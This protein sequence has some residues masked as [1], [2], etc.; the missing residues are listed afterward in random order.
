MG[1]RSMASTRRLAA[2]L[3][4]DVAGYSRLMGADEEGTLGR[5]KAYRRELIDPK[6]ARASRAASSR[7]PATACWSSLP[8]SVDAV[9][10]AVEVQRGMIERNA[11]YRRR[12]AHRL[13]RRHQSRRR[14]RR[15]RRHLRRRRQRRRAPRSACR[16]RRY[17]HFADGARPDPRQAALPV[18]RWGEQS[19]K[20][21][22]RPSASTRCAPKPSPLCLRRAC[23]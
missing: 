17:L 20:N 9:R 15:R 7:P 14:D 16:P 5:L 23:A 10:C 22:A 13:P 21:I 12:P 19:V 11:G 8:V 18:R 6:I 2:I 1:C 3:A 4:A